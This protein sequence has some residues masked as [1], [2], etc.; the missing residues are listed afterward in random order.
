MVWLTD[1]LLEANLRAAY[2]A[3]LEAQ[4]PLADRSEGPPPGN[5]ETTIQPI[6]SPGVKQVIAN[7]VEQQ[8]R[9]ERAADSNPPAKPSSA[10]VPDALNPAERLFVV[11]SNLSVVMV[12]GQECELR[13]VDA[14]ARID[15]TAGNDNKVRVIV[16]SSRQ[17]DCSVGAIPRVAVDDLQ[18]MRNSFQEEL[19]SGLRMLAQKSG[20]GGLPKAP[21]TGVPNGEV[22]FPPPDRGV[23]DQLVALQVQAD[24][25]EYDAA[26]R[27]QNSGDLKGA[28]ALFQ[29]LAVKAGP[30][31]SQAQEREH[32]L[33]N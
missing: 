33:R 3:A 17:N 23:A 4:T 8:L 25:A 12:G 30:V 6:V 2:E 22:P 18:E 7:E 9:G 29:A 28:L 24:K 11:S 27:I 13:P 32:K 20:T 19:D 1:Y 31:Q 16:M 26:N 15:A 21:D 5:P 14:I 10:Q